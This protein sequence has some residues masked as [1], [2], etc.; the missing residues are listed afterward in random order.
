[1]MS[2]ASHD[3]HKRGQN[4]SEEIIEL[5]D[6][7]TTFD[8]LTDPLIGLLLPEK[9]GVLSLAHA[10]VKIPG[11][12]R[13]YNLYRKFD[14]F[15]RA[16]REKDLSDSVRFSSQLFGDPKNAREN[17]LRLVQYIDKA[18][19][20][21]VVDYMVNAS[22]SAGNGL[23]T[24]T[25]YYRILWALT[26]TYSEDLHYFK[27][28]AV[29]DDVIKGNTQIIALTQSGLMISAGSD[30]N[31]SVEDQDYAV[32]SFGVMVDQY[33][34]SFEDEERWEYWRSREGQQ[35]GLNFKTN[36]AEIDG[37]TLILH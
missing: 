12:I 9:A 21:T 5:K 17:A 27:K 1:M 25:E 29:E 30:S 35:N 36:S 11:T 37:N 28:I 16:I 2:V 23:I 15:L 6:V 22:R 10:A 26:N 3:D 20:L 32:T 34:L 8:A 19:T 18:E 4:M 24:E 7:V 13:D 31:R 14:H 33:A